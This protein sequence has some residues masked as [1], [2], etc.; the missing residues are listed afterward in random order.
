MKRKQE[1]DEAESSETKRRGCSYK[2][3]TQISHTAR[4][5]HEQE[6]FGYREERVTFLEGSAKVVAIAVARHCLSW[7]HLYCWNLAS[8][9]YPTGVQ[10][11]SCSIPTSVRHLLST[12]V[13]SLWTALKH[14][15]KSADESGVSIKDYVYNGGDTSAVGVLLED[16][17]AVTGIFVATISVMLSYLT[18]NPIY[19]AVGS[20]AIG[21]LLGAVALF[22]VQ[23]NVN[24]LI[25]RYVLASFNAVAPPTAHAGPSLRKD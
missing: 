6:A 4:L 23:I 25:G 1:T 14:V 12:F 7:V 19:D 22:L 18:L 21:G 2:K 11:S 13:A 16:G 3:A 20:I 10:V 17:A 15:R 24:A 5:E 8:V 9:V